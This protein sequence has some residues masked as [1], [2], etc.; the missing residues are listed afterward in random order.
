MPGK[1]YVC[2]TPIGNL[3]DVSIR[4]LKTLRR[5]DLIACED[6]R[7]TI[8]LLNRYKI[9]NKLLSYHEHSQPHREQYI[10]AELAQ[11]RQ[12]ALVSDA[13]M[14]A[15]SDP[16]QDLVSRAR[17][18]GIEVEVIPGPSACTAALAVSGLDSSAFIFAGFLPAKTG[19][20]RQV[21]ANLKTEPRTVILY[22]APHRLLKTLAD[23]G[24]VMGEGRP[25]T[26]VRELT[27][28]HQEVRQGSIDEVYN[29]YQANPPRG[30]ICL[31]L[32]GYAEP[33][34]PVDMERI[35]QE[36]AALISQGVDK[37]EAFK[38]KAREYN[39]KKSTIY[40]QFLDI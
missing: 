37:K 31:L 24:A 25:I 8:K 20:R 23:M 38:T 30:E 33:A 19:Q 35:V 18:A 36:T 15:I 1:L 40:K 17:A 14:P 12:I 13:G 16:G 6:T 5:V 27:K 26:V 11:G 4:L 39:V 7:H 22:E 32:P 21:L 3:E 28:L 2:G 10:L 9:K 34:E 29:Y